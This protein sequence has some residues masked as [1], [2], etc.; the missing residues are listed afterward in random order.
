MPR[1]SIG[2][3]NERTKPMKIF[4][5]L[6]FAAL[7]VAL[8]F[9]APITRA[10]DDG[11]HHDQRINKHFTI[12]LDGIYKPVALGDG[13]KDNLG[14]TLV[15]LNDGS[16]SKVK[17]YS[18]S[19][20]PGDKNKAIGTFYVQFAGSLCAYDLPGG[21]FTAQF[22]GS[23]VEQLP[24]MPSPG[25]SWTWDGTFKLEILEATGIYRRFAGGHIHMVD[26]L[27]F[28]AGDG[29]FLEDCFC[30]FHRKLVKP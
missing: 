2:R 13:P 17:I 1:L 25:E 3:H 18:V 14:L 20:L 28:R 29:T 21:A 9:Q 8:L 11:Q 15:D 19:G 27:K 6:A 23:D 10:D 7:A 5:N 4:K 12:L 22:V 16:Y 30:H 26:I 24:E